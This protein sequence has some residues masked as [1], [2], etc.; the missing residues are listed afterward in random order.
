MA[1]TVSIF[2]TQPQRD[3]LVNEYLTKLERIDSSIVDE[4]YNELIHMKNPE[5]FEECKSFMP[6]CIQEL[7]SL[8]IR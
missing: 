3:W 8:A 1:A 7:K 2:L 5:F 6:L 4:A